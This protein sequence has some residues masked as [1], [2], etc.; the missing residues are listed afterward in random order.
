[1]IPTHYSSGGPLAGSHFEFYNIGLTS[2][3]YM[4]LFLELYSLQLPLKVINANG[5][6]KLLIIVHPLLLRQ[7]HI[8][9]NCSAAALDCEPILQTYNQPL[10]PHKITG[11]VSYLQARCKDDT[12]LRQCSPPD[13]RWWPQ[14]IPFSLSCAN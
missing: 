14:M 10:S 11:Q 4:E 6:P 5:F 2:F 9:K 7:V 3:G 13:P 8:L 12:A 1:M